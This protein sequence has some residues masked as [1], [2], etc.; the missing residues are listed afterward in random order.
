MGVCGGDRELMC[1]KY[2]ENE[3]LENR[4][5]EAF[6][7][8]LITSYDCDGLWML[9]GRQMDWSHLLVHFPTAQK[10]KDRHHNLIH[11]F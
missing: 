2:F 3:D 6:L 11:G 10:R 8:F 1:H 9:D 5:S 4:L 7:S